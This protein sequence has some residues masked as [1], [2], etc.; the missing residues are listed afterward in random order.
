MINF[1]TTLA[2]IELEFPTA[3]SAGPI[4][5]DVPSM[6]LAS[7]QYG[8]GAVISKTI[9]PEPEDTPKPNMIIY[10]N[11]MINYEWQAPGINEILDIEKIGTIHKPVIA[12]IAGP[13]DQLVLMA[14]RL[15]KAGASMIEI[16]GS[17]SIKTMEEKIKRLKEDIGIPLVV[18]IGS[19]IADVPSYTKGLEKAGVDVISGIN[20]IGPGLL[21]D[22]N[23]SK[24]LLGSRFGYGYVS[25]AAIKPI[26]LRIIAEIAKSTKL[27]ILGGG[28]ITRGRDAIEMFM[29]GANCIHLHTEA[30]LKGISIFKTIVNEI[31]E[32]LDI[33]GYDS[34]EDIIGASLPYIKDEVIFDKKVA[35]INEK[36]CNGCGLCER[37][38][39]YKAPKKIELVAEINRDLCQGCG[40][41][42]SIC[43]KGAIELDER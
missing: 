19:G 43:P 3:V 39:V 7:Q 17:G 33:R 21:I 25:G 37:V 5:R 32:F 1:N 10:S 38:C 36:L 41:C 27:P 30:I 23:S 4:T 11:S 14:K 35:I 40:L 15:E 31:E 16:G 42:P 18:K 34:V 13:I 26:A 22:I 8:I 24:P 6:S 2:D 29:V 9:L 20:S 28:G 12:N